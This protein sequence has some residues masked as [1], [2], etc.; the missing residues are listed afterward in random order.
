MLKK[1]KDFK[2]IISA[3]ILVITVLTL[4]GNIFSQYIFGKNMDSVIYGAYEYPIRLVIRSFKGC[5]TAEE[6]ENRIEE[7]NTNDWQAQLTAID[8]VSGNDYAID[9]IK[10]YLYD[11]SFVNIIRNGYK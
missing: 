4:A 10:E 3:A 2:E 7:Y 1:I 11:P 6:V 9:K 8:V 5:K